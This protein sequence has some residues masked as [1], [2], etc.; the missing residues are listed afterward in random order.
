MTALIIGANGQDGFYLNQLLIEKGFEVTGI[1]RAGNF[2]NID[3]SDFAVVKVKTTSP[4]MM[5]E[6][7]M[8]IDFMIDNFII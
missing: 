3:I 5:I 6:F 8:M 1:S 2:L 4:K 7:F